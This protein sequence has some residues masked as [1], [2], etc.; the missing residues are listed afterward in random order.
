MNGIPLKF[1]LMTVTLMATV[2]HDWLLKSL[3]NRLCE[4]FQTLHVVQI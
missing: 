3:Q 2:I 4:R 1:K